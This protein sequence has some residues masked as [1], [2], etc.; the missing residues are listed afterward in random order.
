[1]QIDC[2]GQAESYQDTAGG[3]LVTFALALVVVFLVLAAVRKL[4]AT[5]RH[6]FVGAARHY[7]DAG[8][9]V[10]PSIDVHAQVGVVMPIGLM[11]KNGIPIVEFANQFRAGSRFAMGV[12]IIGG[13]MAASA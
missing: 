3:I 10:R 7:R 8:H 4:P 1:M 12:V 11:A 2:G 5:G 6:P 13:F 9:D